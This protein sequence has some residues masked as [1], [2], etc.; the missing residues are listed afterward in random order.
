M[1]VRLLPLLLLAACSIAPPPPTPEA[2]AVPA[3]EEEGRIALLDPAQAAF[4]VSQDMPA[5]QVLLVQDGASVRPA[6]PPGYAL[7]LLED[8]EPGLTWRLLVAANTA[9]PRATA[10]QLR[11]ALAGCLGRL[12]RVT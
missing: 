6:G 7:T 2:V 10:M 11:Q 9:D 4:C 3:L 5:S 1:I 8:A 12:G